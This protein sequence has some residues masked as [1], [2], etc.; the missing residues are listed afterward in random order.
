[1]T[2]TTQ[3]KN[4]G[5]KNKMSIDKKIL[6]EAVDRK[7]IDGTAH[8]TYFH[9][10]TDFAMYRPTSIEQFV[11]PFTVGPRLK[12]SKTPQEASEI[13]RIAKQAGLITY[14]SQE[15]KDIVDEFISEG[16]K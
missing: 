8:S 1:M 6:A 16:Y 4:I 12:L 5:G 9:L 10:G 14:A 13:M 2:L 11:K 7:V 3:T 15:A